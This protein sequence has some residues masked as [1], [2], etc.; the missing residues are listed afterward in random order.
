MSACHLL[1]VSLTRQMCAG[2][3]AVALIG[4]RLSQIDNDD[5]LRK[6]TY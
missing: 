6:S 5:L 3:A 1:K 4:K 2:N